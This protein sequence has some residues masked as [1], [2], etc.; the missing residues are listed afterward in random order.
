M[1]DFDVGDLTLEQDSTHEGDELRQNNFL[2]SFEQKSTAIDDEDTFFTKEQK[3]NEI[4]SQLR[5][6]NTESLYTDR[7]NV[8]ARAVDKSV[9]EMKLELLEALRYRKEDAMKIC[10]TKIFNKIKETEIKIDAEELKLKEV[11]IK[12]REFDTRGL[13]GNVNA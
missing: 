2:K 1:W 7:Q 9:T 8:E 5:L 3:S 11:K 6:D 13:T 12:I 10:T 4:K